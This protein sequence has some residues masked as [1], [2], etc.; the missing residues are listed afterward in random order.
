MY[1][2]TAAMT[3]AELTN[4]NFMLG[5][6]TAPAHWNADW[7]GLEN[8]KPV[9]RMRE[10]VECIQKMWSSDLEHPV[11]YQGKY[12]NVKNYGRFISAPC[13]KIPIYLAAVQ[14]KMCCKTQ[15]NNSNLS[16]GGTNV[17]SRNNCTA[18]FPGSQ[19]TA[20]AY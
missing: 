11:D 10:Y 6:G 3:L 12:I 15:S 16:S 20:C 1:T 13:S 19:I 17:A 7:H 9:E 4:E 5:L 2:E 8:Y 18:Y 14:E